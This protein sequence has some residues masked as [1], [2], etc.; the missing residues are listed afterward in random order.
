MP[1]TS[2]S[3][4]AGIDWLQNVLKMLTVV[5]GLVAV[6]WLLCYC[7]SSKLVRGGFVD[8]E[9]QIRQVAGRINGTREDFNKYRGTPQSQGRHIKDAFENGDVNWVPW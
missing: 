2:G 3:V 7:K 4:A 5:L 8:P 1:F 9:G 6:I